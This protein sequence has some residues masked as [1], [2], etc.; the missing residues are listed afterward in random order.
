MNIEDT[1]MPCEER[2]DDCLHPFE[3]EAARSVAESGA[4]KII[5]GVSGG[6]DSVSMLL[7]LIKCG[8]TVRAVHCNFHLRGEESERDRRF[9][10]Q[11]CERFAVPLDIVDFD[12]ERYMRDKRISVEMACRELRYAEFR[13]IM[14]ETGC[15]RIAVAHNSDDNAETLILN[16]MR[17]A[18]VSG[19]RGMLP[20]TGEIIRP[21]LGVDRTAIL[22]YLASQGEDYVTDSTN[23]SSDYA[24]NFV[25]NEVLPLLETRW[26]ATRRSLSRTL[27]IMRQEE[28]MLRWAENQFVTPDS[29]SLLYSAVEACPDP[30]W[31]VARFATRFGASR[32]QADEMLRSI[33]SRNFEPGRRWKVP[34]GNLITGRDS[35]CFVSDSKP[36]VEAACSEAD[37]TPELMQEIVRAPLKVLWT[38]LS[39]EEI[40]FRTAS[41]GDRIRPLGMSGSTLLS[42]I[43]KDA[44]LSAAEKRRVAVAVRK[45]N[46]EIIWAQG[47]KRSRY[48]LV[49]QE[50]CKAYKYDV[51]VTG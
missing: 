41:E 3:Q 21:L 30:G 37:V 16:L 47:I 2:G 13:R 51:K 36:V 28:Q 24:R 14:A 46:G 44:R 4:K 25:R 22:S 12:V 8:V 5:A 15:D 10:E 50:C 33:R 1:Q 7:A 43:M 49:T 19:L 38:D 35:I 17:G 42:K 40:E 26:P 45:D 23:L 18:G 27:G 9:V 34:G 20:D 11:L 31:I 6:A 39:P 29:K 48:D 32:M